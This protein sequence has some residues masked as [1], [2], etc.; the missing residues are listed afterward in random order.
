VEKVDCS[1]HIILEMLG[2][3]KSGDELERIGES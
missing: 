1:H 3:E 2:I